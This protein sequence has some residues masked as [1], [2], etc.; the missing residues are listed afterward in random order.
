MRELKSFHAVAPS[1]EI[2]SRNEAVQTRKAASSAYAE[3]CG[4]GVF[5]DTKI[6]GTGAETPMSA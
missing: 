4:K 1:R 5:P 2:E 6:A 3:T